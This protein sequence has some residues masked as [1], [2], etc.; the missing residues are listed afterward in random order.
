MK[1]VYEIFMWLSVYIV[2]QTGILYLVYYHP[3]THTYAQ[4]TPEEHELQ[5]TPQ[6]MYTPPNL[7]LDYVIDLKQDCYLIWDKQGNVSEV[8]FNELEE[9]FIDDNM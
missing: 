1:R 8:P 2:I 7:K 3:H 4:C 9:W 6:L 5:W